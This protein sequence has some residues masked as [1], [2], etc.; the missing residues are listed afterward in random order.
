MGSGGSAAVVVEAPPA[1]AAVPPFF[2]AKLTEREGIIF[3][4]KPGGSVEG[5]ADGTKI[6]VVEVKELGVGQGE[7]GAVTIKHAGKQ[8]VLPPERVILADTLRRSPD[9]SYA[10]F[11]AMTGCGDLCHTV[12]YVVAADG[13]RAKLGEGGVDL[14]ASWQPNVVAIGS[15]TLWTVTLPDLKVTAHAGYTA[16]AYGPDGTLYVRDKGGSAFK[17][18]DGKATRVWKST[19]E[20]D[21]DGSDPMPVTFVGG[22]PKFEIDD[23]E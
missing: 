20:P 8:L 1:D 2:P 22:K 5:I 9:G 16:P 10:V 7:D 13:R 17:L 18:V 19:R 3:A 6:E 14:V 11:Y 4:D 21:E 12:L 23:F 15:A